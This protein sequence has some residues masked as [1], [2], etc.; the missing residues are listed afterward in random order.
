[1]TEPLTNTFKRAWIRDGFSTDLCS[2][3]DGPFPLATASTFNTK[4]DLLDRENKVVVGLLLSVATPNK[5]TAYGMSLYTTNGG[6]KRTKV[7][8]NYAFIMVF[9]DLMD[10]PNCFAVILH[11]KLDFQN[12]F[13]AKS[14]CEHI[15]IGDPICFVEPCPTDNKL[16][17]KMTVLKSPKLAVCLNCHTGWPMRDLHISSNAYRQVAFYISGKKLVFPPSHW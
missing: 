2:D 17:E 1:M 10:L 6:T 9:A 4:M 8:A 16:G 11:R 7:Q 3:E 12:M 5:G 14:N 13:N 15:T